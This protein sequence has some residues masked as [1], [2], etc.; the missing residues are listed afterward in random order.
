MKIY[1]DCEFNDFGGELI[2]MAMV[3][4]K[5]A[6]WYESLGCDNPTPWVVEHIMPVIFKIPTSKKEF[7]TSLEQFLT[8]FTIVTIIA[9]WPED[10]AHFCKALTF[11]GPGRCIDIP[12]MTFSLRRDISVQ[13]SKVPHNAL[14]DAFALYNMFEGHDK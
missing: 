5:G 3:T 10:I 1:L 4:E 11:E 14:S 13:G 2:S 7:H 8:S 12:P 9:D 6:I